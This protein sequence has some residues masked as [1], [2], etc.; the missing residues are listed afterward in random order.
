MAY[1][2]P[3]N[4]GIS[5]T[6]LE[7]IAQAEQAVDQFFVPLIADSLHLVKEQA[8]QNLSGVPFTSET[9]THTI[10]KR[11][12]RGAASVQVQAPYGSPFRGRLF[13]SAKTRYGNNP[14]YDYLAILE[15]GHDGIKPKY[16]PTARRGFVSKARLTIPGGDHQLVH[17]ENGFRG[18]TGRYTFVREI[19]PMA[20]KY[21]MKSALETSTD[22]IQVHAEGMA[23]RFIEERGL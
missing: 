1:R 3:V 14:E 4:L 20:G 11:T 7:R 22:K 19:P 23:S 16:T 18:I 9:G 17:G 2:L 6:S 5:T 21:W 12:G 13:A 15:Y 10:Q 8:V